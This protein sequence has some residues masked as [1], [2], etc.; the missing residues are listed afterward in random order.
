MTERI[1]TKTVMLRKVVGDAAR[2][3]RMVGEA[4]G[5]WRGSAVDFESSWQRVRSEVLAGV[6]GDSTQADR[7]DALCRLEDLT[8]LV[9]V[10]AG[11]LLGEEVRSIADRATIEAV[12]DDVAAA[13][14]AEPVKPTSLWGR[15]TGADNPAPQPT[16]SPIRRQNRS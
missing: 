12:V 7:E 15:L 4:A 11:P 13:G 10:N 6:G 16:S 14:P 9:A 2:I 8:A 3:V 1:D 5:V